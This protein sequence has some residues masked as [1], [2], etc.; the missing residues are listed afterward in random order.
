MIL[1]RAIP[2]LVSQA[3]AEDKEILQWEM[4]TAFH[5]SKIQQELHLQ[6][7]KEFRVSW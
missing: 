7:P 4:I 1:S 6:F 3:A 5:E 2:I